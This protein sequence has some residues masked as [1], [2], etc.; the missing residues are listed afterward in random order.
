MK[1]KAVFLS[2]LV[3][4]AASQVFAKD[5]VDELAFIKQLAAIS[6]RAEGLSLWPGFQFNAKPLIV[7][8]ESESAKEDNMHLYAFNLAAKNTEW[9]ALAIKT[10][11]KPVYFMSHDG[12]GMAG[13]YPTLNKPYLNVDGQ[14]SVP[15]QFI[16]YLGEDGN[17]SSM[18]QIPFAFYEQVQSPYA[19]T[20]M[21]NHFKAARYPYD[22]FNKLESVT[23]LLLQN[24][25][26]ADYFKNQNQESLKDY[27]AVYQYRANLLEKDALNVEDKLLNSRLTYVSLKA[28]YKNTADIYQ[29]LQKDLI[30]SDEEIDAFLTD[31]QHLSDTLGNIYYTLLPAVGVALDDLMPTWKQA[32]ESNQSSANEMLVQHFHMSESELAA[33]VNAVKKNYAYAALS[34]QVKA[35]ISPY[36]DR[37]QEAQMNYK[38]MPGVELVVPSGGHYSLWLR[39][40]DF[41]INLR[42]SLIISISEGELFDGRVTMRSI[43]FMYTYDSGYFP[44]HGQ[45]DV[46]TGEARFK[47]G[48]GSLLK[49]D[50]TTEITLDVFM[51]RKTR[52]PFH[53]L[54]IT[55][56]TQPDLSIHIQAKNAGEQ[57]SI[58]TLNEQVVVKAEFPVLKRAAVSVFPQLK[59]AH[60]KLESK[61]GKYR[62]VIYR[63]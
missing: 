31:P 41:E 36:L 26:L 16:D 9:Q 18:I 1:I 43:P 48:L 54:V 35:K 2:L 32:V 51:K 11:A 10:S 4:C 12:I 45:A 39:G 58:E 37:M 22:E 19:K 3:L 57:Y 23:L 40:D 7:G 50:G 33:R 30:A 27:A 20:L 53:E 8:F 14:D 47:L 55:D 13:F 29:A 21:E 62:H 46:G 5:K 44:S 15:A 38:N 24:K 6:Q 61:N 17:K 25:I 60:E 59:A 49:L 28:V 56:K 34:N 63:R 52:I 42:N